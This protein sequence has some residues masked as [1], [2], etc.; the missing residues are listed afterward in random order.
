V[1]N[2]AQ[3]SKRWHCICFLT[4]R[5][6]AEA[7]GTNPLLAISYTKE[8]PMK[9]LRSALAVFAI[10][11]IATAAHAQQKKVSSMIPFNFAVGDR[12]YTA[13]TYVFTQDGALLRISDA[14]Q[15][16]MDVVLSSPCSKLM[17]A[18]KTKLVFRRMGDYYFLEQVWVAGSQYGRSLP[19]SH[20]ETRLAQ[21]HPQEELVIVAANL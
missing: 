16:P 15:T 6:T 17:P 18:E 13:G 14:D 19:K 4:L 21:N 5:H 20:M 3:R 7:F 12:A 10:L 11:L 8:V 1:S 9:V 2:A